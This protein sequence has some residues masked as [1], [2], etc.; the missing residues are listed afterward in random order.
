MSHLFNSANSFVK[1][2]ALWEIVY[3]Q[4]TV[5]DLKLILGEPQK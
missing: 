3:N 1:V 2:C 4:K 5:R